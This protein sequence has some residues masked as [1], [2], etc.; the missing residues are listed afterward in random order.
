MA[1]AL[2]SLAV[3]PEP[4]LEPL[5]GLLP[6]EPPGE[7]RPR[8]VCRLCGA[9]LT[10]REARLWAMG[11]DCRRKLGLTSGPGVGRFEVPQDG[12]FG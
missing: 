1:F 2:N 6:T 9:P 11:R 7:G 10:A 5:P 4:G 8:V 12:L 3:Q